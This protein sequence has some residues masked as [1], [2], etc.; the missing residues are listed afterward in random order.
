MQRSS[1][2]II[3]S[4]Q[5]NPL[6]YHSLKGL[7]ISCWCTSTCCNFVFYVFTKWFLKNTFFALVLM[8]QIKVE[9]IIAKLLNHYDSFNSVTFRIELWGKWY[10]SSNTRNDREKASRDSTFRRN[11][12]SF[13]KF[14][15]SIIHTTRRHYCDYRLHI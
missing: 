7:N 11:T 6:S 2:I 1:L 8:K 13:H 14:S 10:Y 12:H 3:T 9:I 5:T 4:T 15:S